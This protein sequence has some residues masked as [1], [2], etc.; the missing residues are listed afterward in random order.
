[1]LVDFFRGSQHSR[2]AMQIAARRPWLPALVG[3]S[4]LSLFMVGCISAP[5]ASNAPAPPP[6]SA[7]AQLEVTPN[8][9]SF[10]S[11]VV[12]VQN[13]Q[14]LKLSNTGGTALTLTGIIA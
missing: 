8:A 13:S 2:Q 10:S 14:T 7:A 5:I 11:S 4:A 3:I 6:V 9:I 12:G 1:M